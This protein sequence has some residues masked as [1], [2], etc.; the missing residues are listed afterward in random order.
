MSRRNFPITRDDA[1]E[2]IVAVT[3]FMLFMGL[4]TVLIVGPG[5]FL[6]DIDDLLSLL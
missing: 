3:G 6:P 5:F 2:I 4:I 1:R